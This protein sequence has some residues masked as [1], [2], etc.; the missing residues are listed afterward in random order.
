LAAGES[1]L[2]PVRDAG[3]IYVIASAG[4]NSKVFFML[5]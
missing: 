5:V 2:V 4:S 1:I 3:L